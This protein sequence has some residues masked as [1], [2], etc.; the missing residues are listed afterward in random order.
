[1]QPRIW[2]LLACEHTFPGHVDF[3]INQQP[4]VL[5]LRAAL[6]PFST[7]PVSVLG[8]V[9]THLQDL[10]F[11][12]VGL[13]E[14][15]TGPPLEPVKVPLH[16]IPSLQ[17]VDCTTYLGVVGKLAEVALDGTVH[18]AKKDIKQHLPQY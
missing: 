15:C 9:L 8:I 1:M 13:Y 10:A 11:G 16:G 6:N 7:Q 12:L 3:L 5:L 14:V 4:Q 17:C 18:I 2:S